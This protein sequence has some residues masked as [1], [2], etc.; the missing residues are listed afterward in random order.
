MHRKLSL[1]LAASGTAMAV[2]AGTFTLG[3][4]TASA[5]VAPA[6]VVHSAHA[7]RAGT[8]ATWVRRHRRAIT[9]AAIDI[10]AQTI[11]VTPR[12]LVV[13]LRSGQTIAE[14]ATAHNVGVTT[15]TNALITAGDSRIQTLLSNGKITTARADRLRLR[16]ERAVPKLVNHRF[17]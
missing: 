17:R 10:T 14:V 15:V 13:S 5:S 11:G 4:T 7:T 8:V 6:A 1:L 3:S 12:S 16:L 2:T 9:R